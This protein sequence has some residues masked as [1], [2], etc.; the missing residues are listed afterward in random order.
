MNNEIDGAD[1]GDPLTLSTILIT[2][3]NLCNVFTIELTINE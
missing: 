1:N 2:I 3:C